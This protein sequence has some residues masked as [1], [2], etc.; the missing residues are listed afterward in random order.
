MSV[1]SPSDGRT[2]RNPFSQW[3]S[4]EPAL[5]HGTRHC[6]EISDDVVP[7]LASGGDDLVWETASIFAA[8]PSL[9][10]EKGS[11]HR[12]KYR[13]RRPSNKVFVRPV[14]N[15][16]TAGIDVS[17]YCMYVAVPPDRDP[18]PIRKFNAFTTDLRAIGQW[19][20][21]CRVRSV[22]ME[23]TGVYWIPLYQIL[24]DEGFDVCLVNARHYKNVPG[25][26]TDVC[27]AAW[28]QYLH[29]VGLLLAS[30]RPTQ[31]ICAIRSI[32]RYRETLIRQAAEQV[33][34]MQ[35]ALDEM[36]LHLHH[37]IDDLTGKTG[38]AI[39]NAILQGERDP[40]VLARLREKNVK[41]KAQTI[42]K[43]L[44]G[45]YR[46]EHV[47]VL[48]QAFE[49]W[50]HFGDQ[51][52]KCDHQ[53]ERMTQAL[54]AIVDTAGYTPL[55]RPSKNQPQGDWGR[56]LYGSFGVDLTAVPSI[57][58]ATVLVLF[59]EI[60]TDWSRFPTASQFASWLTACPDNDTS[61]EKVLRRKTRRS[62]Q[63][64]KRALRLAAQSLRHNKTALGE[65]YR[66]LRA[67]LGTP[68]ALTAMAHALARILWYMVT[69]K[70]PYDESIF[71][72]NERKYQE[73]RRK[74]LLKEA[75]SLGLQLTEVNI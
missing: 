10:S 7:R 50:K 57:N 22:A 35:K 54:G 43:A 1:Y 31:E 46:T 19:L 2:S 8:W 70:T 15:P 49:T 74:R 34:R 64:V 71:A 13:N 73:R 30:F 63:R 48:G 38:L 36:N 42:E 47:F 33:Q 62:S 65:K 20:K 51:I 56:L 27:D 4:C 28:L 6:V 32:A 44:E 39:V 37:V 24:T 26:K 67:H 58:V 29:S 5:Q 61:G 12:K 59:T 17:P 52:A 11:M 23:S 3:C 14:T 18:E 68:K 53:M 60:G 25:R 55:K 40:H 41:A 69:H 72:E 9:P 45:D 16:D 66:R 75:R 21:A